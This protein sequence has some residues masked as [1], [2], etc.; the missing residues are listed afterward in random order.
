MR[1]TIVYP[2]LGRGIPRN[3]RN[4]KTGL[5]FEEIEFD[6]AEVSGDEAPVAFLVTKSG[7]TMGSMPEEKPLRIR[8]FEGS[9]YRSTAGNPRYGQDYCQR[10]EL[11]GFGE[12][13]AR[14]CEQAI[15][16]VEVEAFGGV[17]AEYW[18][19]SART[20]KDYN[21]TAIGLV[22][23]RRPADAFVFTDEGA[24]EAEQWRAKARRLTDGFLMVDGELWERCDEPVY[25]VSTR[26]SPGIEV[27]GGGPVT[28]FGSSHFKFHGF[29]Q[30][31]VRVFTAL[32]YDLALEA[33]E[34]A[35]P[36]RK[37]GVHDMDDH[38][39]VLLPEAVCYPAAERELDRLARDLVEDVSRA[40]EAGTKRFGWQWFGGMPGDVLS[41]WTEVR[42]IVHSYDPL[43]ATVPDE[44][45]GAVE[46]LAAGLKRESAL[47]GVQLSTRV[48]EDDYRSLMGRWQDREIDVPVAMA[49]ERR[50]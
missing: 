4:E 42:D 9:L 45:E 6:V 50:M 27:V 2:V 25:S 13:T 22:T 17:G 11:P 41:A 48:T 16:A 35:E 33:R 44:L 5:V 43:E 21:R 38:I 46:R 37:P 19:I 30:P 40:V 15:T 18:P 23:H 34:R 14:L 12:I 3:A 20:I 29:V 39:E 7:E 31:S 36:F 49:T 28:A 1:A 8:S 10:M 47:D 32:E 24:G 26:S